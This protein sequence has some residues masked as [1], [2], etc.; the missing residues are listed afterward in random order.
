[1]VERLSRW[2]EFQIPVGCPAGKIFLAPFLLVKAPLLSQQMRPEISVVCRV[3]AHVPASLHHWFVRRLPAPPVPTCHSVN[4]PSA[5]PSHSLFLTSFKV[6]DHAY[7]RS[8]I[9]DENPILSKI[10]VYK[11]GFNPENPK[12]ASSTLI[13]SR[14]IDLSMFN[15]T[16]IS[17][18]RKHWEIDKA[19]AASH[20]PERCVYRS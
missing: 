10:Q 6:Q 15:D 13:L 7:P 11:S 12:S 3:R 8:F 17:E 1:V 2:S 14:F 4:R 5:D 9:G 16:E 19:H 20:P 18:R